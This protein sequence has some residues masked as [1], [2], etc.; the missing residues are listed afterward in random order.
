MSLS[1]SI[2][3]IIFLRFALS[4][5]DTIIKQLTS[6]L[7]I[8]THIYFSSSEE[9]LEELSLDNY[10]PKLLIHKN[11]SEELKANHD[12]PVIVIIQLEKDLNLS[13]EAVEVL[14]LYLKDRQ[15]ND[16]LLI[17]EETG[18]DKSYLEICK[19]FWVAGFPHVLI[20]NVQEQ[21]RTI[22][23]YPYLEIKSTNLTEYV[24]N[25]NNRNL[26][27]YPLRVLVTNDP[28]HCFV[29]EKSCPIPRIAIKEV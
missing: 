9:T 5:P 18:N 28:P 11:I 16:I 23:P 26:M 3:I 19:A 14:R 1:K 12:E 24:R 8:K 27:G 2:F 7:N 29:D 4:K 17:E 10:Q 20:Y 13:L 22:E 25:R 15:Y 21:L 6:E